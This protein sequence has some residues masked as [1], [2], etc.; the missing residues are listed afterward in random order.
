[1]K[2]LPFLLT[3]LFTSVLT[4]FGQTQIVD[5]SN[6]V[7][8]VVPIPKNL[9]ECFFRLD[10]LL[11]DSVKKKAIKQTEKRFT[12]DTHFQLG[13]WVRNN[14][15]LWRGSSLSEFFNGK[16][17]YHP[18]D[19]SAIILKSYY[20]RLTGQKI[21][22]EEQIKYYQDYW[23]VVKEPEKELFPKGV[24]GLEFNSRLYYDRKDGMQGLIHVGYSTDTKA[25]WLY[26]YHHGWTKVTKA[27]VKELENHV[28]DREEVLIR[29][30][31]RSKH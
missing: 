22:L 2:T 13:M 20:R 28:K 4:A 7:E 26:D 18:D 19:M 24:K 15:G 17:I 3:F 29:I 31:K 1:M 27:Q 9:E 25:I 6:Q 21:M 14:W 8:E 5:S 11:P 23:K 16:G 10:N 12:A 30:I